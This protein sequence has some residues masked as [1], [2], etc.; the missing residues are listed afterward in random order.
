MMRHMVVLGVVC[1]AAVMT[2]SVLDREA[3]MSVSSNQTS[4]ATQ[5]PDRP[6]STA[7]RLEQNTGSSREERLRSD[8]RGH[9]LGEFRLNGHRV[10]G[11]VDTGAT[12]IAVNETVARR[13]GLRLSRNDFIYPVQTANG[14][15]MAARATLDEVRI[16]SIRVYD[17]DAM[18]LDD[19][20][21]NVVLI[22]M[23][24]LGRLDSFTHEDGQLVLR[25]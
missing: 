13:A 10:K 19:D 24:F 6:Q 14:T 9:H 3:G 7:L 15:V 5:Q 12:S 16:G 4:P 11:L 8:G 22:G 18:V 21:L 25:R 17:V 23:S 20:A 2:A 1:G